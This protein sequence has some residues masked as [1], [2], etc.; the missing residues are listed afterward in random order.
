MCPCLSRGGIWN[1]KKEHDKAA[2]D[3]TAALKLEP[4]NTLAFYGRGYARHADGDHDQAIVDYGQA[5]LIEPAPSVI[6]IAAPPYWRKR[7]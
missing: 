7:I 5:I 2:A 1:F 3:F 4:K 6:T